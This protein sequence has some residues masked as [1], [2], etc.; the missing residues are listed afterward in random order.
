MEELIFLHDFINLIL[1]FI[2]TFV[3]YIILITIFIVYDV[4]A[5]RRNDGLR[6]GNRL[7]KLTIWAEIDEIDG[8]LVIF[9]S[10]KMLIQG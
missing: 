3:G 5:N 6:P 10:C 8:F 2:I 1:I 9:Y 7:K 4:C